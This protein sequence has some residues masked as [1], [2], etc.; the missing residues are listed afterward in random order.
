MTKKKPVPKNLSDKFFDW[1]WDGYEG[2]GINDQDSDAPGNVAH[3]T[4]RG[5]LWSTFC[6]WMR[7]AYAAGYERG[8]RERYERRHLR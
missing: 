8:K 2:G 4:F 1:L 6:D 7:S 3:R 5:H